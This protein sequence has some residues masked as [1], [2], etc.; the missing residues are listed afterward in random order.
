[1]YF[2]I[3]KRIFFIYFANVVYE[4]SGAMWWESGTFSSCF[5]H[6]VASL[7]PDKIH[8]RCYLCGLRE[9]GCV[10]SV[11]CTM[12]W[13]LLQVIVK[14]LSTGTR[15]ILKSFYN[16][17][18]DEVKILG[19]DRFLVAHTSDTLMLGDL[20]TAKLSEVSF[21]CSTDQFRCHSYLFHPWFLIRFTC[22]LIYV[23]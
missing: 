1:M 12:Q 9:V 2:I 7:C 8:F 19:G 13:G 6:Q 17:E 4:T 22:V 10:V 5:S 18:I 15:V 14:N 16:Y 20:T 3:I 11:F 23:L 21:T